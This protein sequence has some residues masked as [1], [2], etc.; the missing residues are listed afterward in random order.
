MCEQPSVSDVAIVFSTACLLRGM[1]RG[2][3]LM[4]TGYGTLGPQ[5][6]GIA[7]E[8]CEE[9]VTRSVCVAS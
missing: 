3:M 2:Q 4:L 7:P 9:V 1:P 6:E 5:Q 8:G